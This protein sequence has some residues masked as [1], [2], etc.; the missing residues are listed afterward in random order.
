MWSPYEFT[1]LVK[2]GLVTLT[3]NNTMEFALKV[4]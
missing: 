4:A 3:E 2:K 1:N